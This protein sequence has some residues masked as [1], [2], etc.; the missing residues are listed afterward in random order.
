MNLRRTIYNSAIPF[1]RPL[2]NAH[3]NVTHKTRTNLFSWRGQFTPQFV[4]SL[5]TTYAPEGVSV[6]DPFAGSGTV[7]LEAGL[8]GFSALGF[9]INPAAVLL[10]KTYE[11]I[12]VKSNTRRSILLSAEATLSKYIPDPLPLFNGYEN[13]PLV[14]DVYMEA[15]HAAD[16]PEVKL[17][18]ETFGIVVDFI[19]KNVHP[20]S[21]WTTWR[22]FKSLVESL[23]ESDQRIQANLGDARLLSCPDNSIDFVLT[24]PPYIN[25][26]NYHQYYRASA[27]MLGW[28]P[29]NVARSEIGS[30]RKFRQN[31]F[32]TVI[33]YCMD[34]SAV[35]YELQRVCHD[36][37]Q[38]IFVVGRESNVRKT[39]F[40]N[41]E[42]IAR[43]ATESLNFN[44][45][46][47]Q[48]RVFSNKFG[49]AIYEDILHWTLPKSRRIF[50]DIIPMAQCI[51]R[52]ALTHA[53][54]RVPAEALFDLE[55]A[56][57]QVEDIKMSPLLQKE[58]IGPET[59]LQG[60]SNI[61]T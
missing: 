51:A 54:E 12:N 48:E 46:L 23:P 32:L 39:A 27:E 56:I 19:G 25:V 61:S 6:L 10:A 26:F 34:L 31:R 29:L 41:S 47:R 33:Q 2:D 16:V 7:L 30:N 36:Q 44:Q 50:D 43:L 9:E 4:E 45:E 21:M 55:A 49:K 22:C 18:L 17:L 38:I 24:S 15:I 11:F 57:E 42:I 59:L 20:S 58:T 3:L 5:L 1:N 37:A 13:M 40:F 35:L 53:R 52:D 60:Y 28:L 8:L 14:K